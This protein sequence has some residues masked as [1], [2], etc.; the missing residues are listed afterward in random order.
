MGVVPIIVRKD[1][2]SCADD[3]NKFFIPYSTKLNN[4]DCSLTVERVVVVRK[5]RVRLPSFTLGEK[6][7]IKNKLAL[8][9]IDCSQS[10][11]PD[12]SLKNNVNQITKLNVENS[13]EAGFG[14]NQ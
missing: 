11:S 2:F 5:T 4:G 10:V 1:F 8:F 12:C 13:G 6:M 7:A 14:V 9:V 3:S